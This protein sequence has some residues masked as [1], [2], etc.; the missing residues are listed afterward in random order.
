MIQ[1]INTNVPSN[2]NV[3]ILQALFEAK[4]WAFGYDNKKINKPEIFDSGFTLL[5]LGTKSEL[6]IYSYMLL[7]MVQEHTPLKIKNIYRMNWNWYN[8]NSVTKFHEDMEEDNCY[9]IAYNLHTND[10]GTEFKINDKIQFYPSIE[11]EAL[12]FPSKL[13]HRGIAPKTT[14]HRFMLN[15]T[16]YL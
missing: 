15:I 8:R 5:S 10:G 14:P 6:E 1:K 12:F 9:S 2:T 3:R 13:L 7:D 16:G 11:G 4:T